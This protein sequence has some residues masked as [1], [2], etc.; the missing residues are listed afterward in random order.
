MKN[1]M[2]ATLAMGVFCA[3][4]WADGAGRIGRPVRILSLSFKNGQPLER[5]RDLVDKEAAQGVDLVIL[6]EVWRGLT[7]HSTETLDGP[8]IQA[9]SALA[10]KHRTYIA[11]PIDRRDG[12]HRFNSVVLLDREGKVAFIYDK[13]FPYWSEFDFQKKIEI[14]RAAPVYQA[15]FGKVGF[16]I[17]FDVNFP[18]VWK[19]LADQGAELV[20]FPSAYSAGT[21]LQAH[22]LT[23]HYYIVSSTGAR[24][25]TVYDITGKQLLYRKSEDINVTHVTLDLDRRIFHTNFNM[26][27]RDKLLREHGDDVEQTEFLEREAWFVLQARRHG[28][29]ARDLARQYG[30]EELRDYVNRS[31]RY[32]DSMRG[33]PFAFAPPA[34]ADVH[35]R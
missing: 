19:S 31:R 28:V 30:L 21:M 24:D 15:D 4:A 18:E 7:D 25:C 5:I 23:H 16:A 11:S 8:A 29:S 32:I 1:C 27:K 13:V 9:M 2:A 26:A 12:D 20:A 17:C 34:S 22:A 10:R 35:A 6:P 14:G 3:G 33:G